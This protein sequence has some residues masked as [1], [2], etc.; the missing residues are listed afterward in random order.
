VQLPLDKINQG[1]A[2]ILAKQDSV[3]DQSNYQLG[4]TVFKPATGVATDINPQQ[5]D[6]T[7]A[8]VGK[9]Q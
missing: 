9:P 6:S 5:S 8:Y 4:L 2:S 3:S 7:C 1:I